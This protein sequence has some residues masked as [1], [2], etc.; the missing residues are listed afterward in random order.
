MTL[1]SNQQREGD[2]CETRP[3]DHRKWPCIRSSATQLLMR[4]TYIRIFVSDGK[5]VKCG[6]NEPLEVNVMYKFQLQY[7]LIGWSIGG[8]LGYAQ[9][10]P[11][12]RCFHCLRQL[13]GRFNNLLPFL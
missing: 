5:P 10:V 8:T 2:Y 9:A 11:I 13:S 6:S 3:C 1:L 12:M 7:G 4:S